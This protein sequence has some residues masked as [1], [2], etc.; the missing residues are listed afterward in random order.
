MIPALIIIS[1]LANTVANVFVKHAAS[2]LEGI[3]LGQPLVVAARLVTN[4]DMYVGILL[5]GIGFAC[6]VVLLSRLRLNVGYPLE[7]SLTYI[8]VLIVSH[9]YFREL[10]SGWQMMGMALIIA[11]VWLTSAGG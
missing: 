5:F 8:A 4:V 7:A 11:G 1:T 10:L 6:Y 3:D 2:K 9:F